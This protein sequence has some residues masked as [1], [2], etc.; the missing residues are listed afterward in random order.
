[1][2]QLKL[3]RLSSLKE[4]QISNKDFSFDISR[5]IAQPLTQLANDGQLTTTPTGKTTKTF[6]FDESE[7]D[8]ADGKEKVI[9]AL[10]NEDGVLAY[11]LADKGWNKMVHVQYIAVDKSIRRGGNARRLVEAVVEWA[12][13]IGFKAVRIEA[14]TNNISACLFWKRCGFVFGGYDE[15]LY[16]CSD[17]VEQEQAVFL[18]RFVE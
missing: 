13:E 1:M 4:H 8:G 11:I 16:R 18:Y 7:F 5:Q 6:E 10:T 9:F 14:Q 3:E 12:K 17:G 15:M 2:S